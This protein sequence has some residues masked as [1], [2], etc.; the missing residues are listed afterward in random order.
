MMVFY[1]LIQGKETEGKN[2]Y[3]ILCRWRNEPVCVCVREYT[4]LMKGETLTG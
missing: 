4:V 2:K 3:G 1:L